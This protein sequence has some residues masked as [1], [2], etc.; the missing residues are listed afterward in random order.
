MSSLLQLSPAKTTY[1]LELI[2]RDRRIA[3]LNN[4]NCLVVIS[5]EKIL[6]KD[7][8][9]SL[10]LYMNISTIAIVMALAS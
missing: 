5:K 2:K 7:C 8:A 4:S 10:E 6:V 3:L 1:Q 9:N